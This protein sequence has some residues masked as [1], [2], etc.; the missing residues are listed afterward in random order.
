VFETETIRSVDVLT[1]GF[2]AEYGGRM[3][4]VVDIKT[5]EGNKK[6]LSGQVSAS[7]FMGKVLVEGPLKRLEET[8]GGSTSF[9]VTAKHS[10][11]N[12]TSPMF[13]PYAISAVD[14]AAA[15]LPFNFTDIYGKISM[16]S[17]NGSKLNLFG[18][19][20]NDRVNYSIADLSWRSSGGGA[21]F[22]LVPPASNFILGG[23]IAFSDYDIQLTEGDNFPRSSRISNYSAQLDFTYF[24]YKSEVKY[25]FIFNGIS[26]DFEFRNFLGVTIEQ[27]D[28]TTELAGFLKY[29]QIIGNLIL[30]PSLRAQVYASQGETSL[31]PR[32]GA[33]YK[34][35]DNVRLK[36]A[37]GLYSQNILS[38]VNERD[39]INLFVGF[40]SGP[41][42]TIFEPGTQVPTSTRLQKAVHAIGGIEVDLSDR[43]EMNVEGYY[44][45]FNQLIE[46]N[47]NRLSVLDPEFVTE[48]GKAYGLD[49]SFRYELPS[50]YLWATY[51]LGYVRRDDGE[52]IYPT[53]FDR[54][55]NV[56]I[57]ATYAFGNN[58]N[59]EASVRWNYGS[60]FP[61]TQTQG[62]Y[63]QID[64]NEQGLNTDPT[65]LNPELGILFAQER[66]GGR[67]SPYHRL[68][69]SVTRTIN[70]SEHASMEIVASATN[71][72]DRQ[73]IFYIDRTT[74]R[75]IYQ[76]PILPALTVRFRF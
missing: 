71:V 72:Y 8:G 16:L 34:V 40:L 68:D 49:V 4:A 65:T 73:N 45:G 56:N 29:K 43:L 25:G 62:F 26:T 18:F 51:S 32:L 7:P 1:G 37:G 12:E 36:F 19:N 6:R 17:G 24:G 13:Y 22:T 15:S 76:L 52:Q 46:L 64:F 61:F 69:L 27:V 39:V 14:S 58:N 20:F 60:P 57:L 3:S 53:V 47:R 5:R 66:N 50:L 31:E 21:N 23:T 59:W 42:Q 2:G 75:E 55:H 10:Y 70:F 67:L 48:T 74:T 30:E 9:L 35:S 38:S 33:K 44:K 41:E 11:I 54:R 28:F 63:G